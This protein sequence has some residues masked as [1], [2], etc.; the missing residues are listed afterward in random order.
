MTQAISAYFNDKPCEVEFSLTLGISPGSGTITF[1]DTSYNIPKKGTLTVSDNEAMLVLFNI[2]AD[3]PRI[4]ANAESGYEL[5]ATIYDRRFTWEWG[6]IV[7]L[8]NQRGVD[9]VPKQERTLQNLLVDCLIALGEYSYTLMDIP[10]AYPEVNWEF[11]NPA[12]AMETLCEQ[13]GLV[14]GMGVYGDNPIIISPYDYDRNMP[15]SVFSEDTAG[16]SADILPS[17]IYVVGNKKVY[18]QLFEDLIPVGEEID[19]TIKRIDDLSY[20]PADWGNEIKCLFA[21]IATAEQRE[22]AKKCIFKWYSIDFNKYPADMVLPLLSEISNVV[23]KEGNEIHEKPYLIG[24]KTLWDGV[25]FV[26]TTQGKISEGF[27]IDKKF[28]IV[29]FNKV[30]TQPKN[31][32]YASGGFESATIDLVAAFESKWGNQED[33]PYWWV[34]IPY[35]TELSVIHKDSSIVAYYV[36]NEVTGTWVFQNSVALNAYTDIILDKLLSYYHSRNPEIKIY[37]GIYAYGAWGEIRN[38]TWRAHSETGATTEVQKHIEIP[39]PLIPSYK[40][41]LAK[42]KFTALWE[43]KKKTEAV[44][45]VYPYE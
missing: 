26:T 43:V 20:A 39:R 25:G 32:S 7:G 24:T 2:Y 23:V 36:K 29:K 11:D 42:R 9:G 12:T 45:R 6:Y 3:K 16:I 4:K 1:A 27:A 15:V 10:V 17:R 40:E 38:V 31:N 41:K 33:F 21:N 18:Q 35:G 28:G 14:V 13:Y 19:G 30:I 34:S 22:L 44:E 8:W 37:P 5:Q